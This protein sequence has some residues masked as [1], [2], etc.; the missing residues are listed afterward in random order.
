MVWVNPENSKDTTSRLHSE[1]SPD[2]TRVLRRPPDT[3]EIDA[4]LRPWSPVSDWPAHP[5]DPSRLCGRGGEL[6]RLVRL[7]P[8]VDAARISLLHPPTLSISKPAIDQRQP[9]GRRG[10]VEPPVHKEAFNL[11]I[12]RQ[13]AKRK[14]SLFVCFCTNH[15]LLPA[16][17]TKPD[18]MIPQQASVRTLNDSRSLHSSLQDQSLMAPSLRH[19]DVRK[20]EESTPSPRTRMPGDSLSMNQQPVVSSGDAPPQHHTAILPCLRL[21]PLH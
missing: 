8:P 4:K 7:A 16:N 3:Q 10:C 2:Q 12:G 1:G 20:A 17:W 5:L 14:S 6:Q 11:Q 19:L 21:N 9:M 18:I 15:P 13:P